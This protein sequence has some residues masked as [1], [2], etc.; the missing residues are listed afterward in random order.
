M[1]RSRG[2]ILFLYFCLFVIKEKSRSKK[3]KRSSRSVLLEGQEV[4]MYRE[5]DEQRESERGI[6]AASILV[7]YHCV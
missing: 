3:K 4:C 6:Y 5:N 2:T 7:Q 1:T